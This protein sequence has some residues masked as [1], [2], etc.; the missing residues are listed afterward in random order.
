MERRYR[1][2]QGMEVS[3]APKAA[4]KAQQQPPPPPAAY[5]AS[6]YAQQVCIM[7]KYSG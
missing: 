4:A 5:S 3:D 7:Q 1:R 2:E 6:S